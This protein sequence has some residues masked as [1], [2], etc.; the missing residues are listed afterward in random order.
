MRKTFV[1]RAAGQAADPEPS[2]RLLVRDAGTIEGSNADRAEADLARARYHSA[3]MDT[4]E[5]DEAITPVLCPGERVLAVRRS[6]VLEFRELLAGSTVDGCR[7]GDLYLTSRRLLVQAHPVLSVELE[8]IEE[9]VVA[10]NQLL[11]TLVDG[12]G[13]RLVVTG[14]R[15]LR[16]QISAARER[17]RMARNAHPPGVRVEPVASAQVPVPARS[18]SPVAD[19]ELV[20]DAADVTLNGPGGEAEG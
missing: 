20:E 5:P 10:G 13:V 6:V 15:L 12:S 3:S 19:S 9:I 1:R 7:A 16:V 18:L 2:D 11:L 4:L 8:R 17:A 14:P